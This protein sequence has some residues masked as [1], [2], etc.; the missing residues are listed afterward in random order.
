MG[1]DGAS[2]YRFGDAFELDLRAY[3]LRRS[4]QPLK[5]PRIPMELLLLLIEQ[6]GQLVTRE[7]IVERVWGK[8][9]FLDTDNSIN[10]AIRKVRQVLADDSDQPSFVQTVTGRGYRFIAPVEE[11]GLEIPHGSEALLSPSSALDAPASPPDVR[12]PDAEAEPVSIVPSPPPPRQLFSWRWGLVFALPI[13]LLAAGIGYLRW[14][15]TTTGR[16]PASGRLMLAVL[17]FSNLTGDSSQEYFS[18]GLTEE[19]IAQLGRLNPEHVGV[20]ARTSVM[21][22]KNGQ[23]ALKAIAH[24]LGAQYV[25]EGSVRR[26][27]DKV[28]V[29]AQLIRVNDQT[30]IWTR[31]YDRELKQLLALQREIAHEI[32]DGIEGVLDETPAV[33]NTFSQSA[34]SAEDYE[35]YDLYLKGLYALNKRTSQSVDQAIGYFQQ[36]TDKNPHF[37]QAYAGLAD[38]YA[39]SHG[40]NLTPENAAMTKARS[41]ALRALEIDNSLAE[42]HTA[43]GLIVQNYDWDWQTAEKEFRRAIQL[44]PNYATAHHWYAEHLA[45]R[46]RFDEAFQESERARQLDPLSLIIATDNGAILYFSRQ[47]GRALQ[48][49]QAVLEME[50]NF[51]RA[52]LRIFAY[53]QQG[54][55]REAL[56]DIEQWRKVEDGPWIWA[57]QAYVYGRSG[58]R[59]QAQ[60]ALEKLKRYNGRQSI[61]PWALLLSHIG[62]GNKELAFATL[63]KAYAQH[64][65]IM[66]TLKVDPVFDPLRT[67]PRFAD[68]TH[69]VGLT[70]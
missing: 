70:E 4:S 2:I 53:T 60:R 13:L 19:M 30:H 36:A 7:E 24:D 64:S 56:A 39:L 11:V 68:F 51:P 35:A 23:V 33:E 15:R 32:S 16:G 38:S 1:G 50:P 21:H 14:P 40:Y 8:E 62:M 43:L 42:A 55:Y 67:D 58:Q 25:L 44:N 18:D 45:W 12:P 5:L 17:P 10:A 37:A 63:E 61:D 34:L 49:W 69:R 22:Y 65:N 54:R 46:G 9:V 31:S 66:T 59:A 26:D 47:Y 28:R 48:K 57:M 29:T 52:H 20:I 3:E 27:D 6:R 41:A